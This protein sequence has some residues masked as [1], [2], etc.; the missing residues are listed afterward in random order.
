MASA[1]YVVE[2]GDT[3]GGIAKK[4]GVSTGSLQ[5]FRSGNADL[6]YPGETL[7]VKSPTNSEATNR[8]STI[9][10][11]LAGDRPATG[12][13]DGTPNGRGQASLDGESTSG[14]FDVGTLKSNVEDAR[15]KRDEAFKK[16]DGFRTS[17]YDELV[18][19]RAL[20]ER[21]DEIASL[22]DQIAEKKRIRDESVNKI[23]SNP[24]ASAATLTGEVARASDKLNADINNLI[25]QRNSV[26]GE[27]NTGLSEI[28]RLVENEAKDIEA[29][30]GFFDNSV[31]EAEQMFQ[32]YQQAIVDELTKEEERAY[33]EASDMRDFEQA[34]QL[35]QMR[36]TGSGSGTNYTILTDQFGRPTV[37]IDRNNPTQQIDVSGNEGSMPTGGGSNPALAQAQAQAAQQS[38]EPGFFGRI[39][40]WFTGN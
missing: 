21:K 5:G 18:G 19:E 37:A 7:S 31:N 16:L 27:Y 38:N 40:N 26:A 2:K 14:G 3:L 20:N 15:T 24:G 30:F 33:D 9:R 35:A 34:L 11:E 22:D 28:E 13:G 6:I 8:A 29:S 39:K 36:G 4:L 23:R 32:A 25:S 10:T 1:Q 12:A 17:R